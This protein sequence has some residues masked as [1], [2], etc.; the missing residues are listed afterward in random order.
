MTLRVITKRTPTATLPSSLTL[1]LPDLSKTPKPGPT[2]R[3]R[4]DVP[5]RSS[6]I[7]ALSRPS[8]PPS[9]FGWAQFTLNALRST[10]SP[11]LSSLFLPGPHSKTAPLEHLSTPRAVNL[12]FAGHR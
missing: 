1:S 4:A 5:W 6:Q 9:P 2:P 10:A 12:P 3:S 7:L 8:S 11:P